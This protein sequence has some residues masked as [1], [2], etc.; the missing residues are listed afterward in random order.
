LGLALCEHI[1]KLSGGRLGVKTKLGE[2]STFWVELALGVGKRALSSNPESSVG[3]SNRPP[4]LGQERDG[5]VVDVTGTTVQG[6]QPPEGEGATPSS[7]VPPSISSEAGMSP[8]T[9]YLPTLPPQSD[10]ALKSIMEHG[11]LVELVVPRRPPEDEVRV[12]VAKSVTSTPSDRQGD[13]TTDVSTVST[14]QA[15]SGDR[16]SYVSMPEPNPMFQSSVTSSGTTS[17]SAVSHPLSSD[18]PQSSSPPLRVLVV[19][20]DLVTRQLMSRMLRRL[21]CIVETAE[22]GQM[23]LQM[24]V[25]PPQTPGTQVPTPT[26]ITAPSLPPSPMRA[27]TEERRFAV[28]FL[29][30]QMVRHL[31][32][33]LLQLE[34]TVY[35][36]SP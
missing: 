10:S 23:A 25:A 24:I 14:R 2:G 4:S 13:I 5:F 9:G 19:D 3:K 32:A 31:L 30:N 33:C 35:Y 1:V 26:S 18:R 11:G 34:L 21:G 17:S 15:R 16:P 6:F 7:I 22:N 20:D 28:V 27:N 12:V 8:E 29:D 36:F